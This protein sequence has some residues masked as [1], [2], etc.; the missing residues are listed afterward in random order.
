MSTA[1]NITEPPA[2]QDVTEINA[3]TDNL[4]RRHSSEETLTA[5][6]GDPNEGDTVYSSH[7]EPIQQIP[8][9]ERAPSNITISSTTQW[10]EIT[11]DYQQIFNFLDA[12]G[13]ISN[14]TVDAAPE[15]ETVG[16]DL[17]THALLNLRKDYLESG[18]IL[19]T[20]NF[21][22]NIPLAHELLR[23]KTHSLGIIR[24][25]GKG[26]F[27]EIV[28]TKL[29]KGQVTCKEDEKGLMIAKWKYKKDVLILSTHHTSKIVNTGKKNKKQEEIFKPQF[30]VDYNYV[31]LYD[32]TTN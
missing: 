17:A 28:T 13:I 1:V 26:I 24:R 32:G 12:S 22:T 7:E 27:K 20:G 5:E 14:I 9:S 21:Y 18:R 25:H 29:S 6:E 3:E 2:L 11:R 23:R 16:K 10:F 30:V 31:N 19:I 8:S 15:A 4:A